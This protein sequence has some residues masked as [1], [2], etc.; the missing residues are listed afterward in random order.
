MRV[1]WFFA[2]LLGLAAVLVYGNFGTIDPCGVLRAR[3]RAEAV[4]SGQ[5]AG[6]I[7]NAMPDNMLDAL[8]AAQY[9]ALSPAKCV[10]LLLEPGQKAT[11]QRA[12]APQAQ[13]SAHAQTRTAA[14]EGVVGL[15]IGFTAPGA[16]SPRRLMV[17]RVW[18]GSPAAAAGVQ[19]GDEIVAVNGQ[20]VSGRSLQDVINIGRGGPGTSVTITIN[21]GGAEREIILTR[22]APPAAEQRN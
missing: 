12:Q 16:D 8:V 18:P 21:R 22:V 14:A 1:I 17:V 13:V 3:V 6:F 20:S 2:F 9:G 15:D 11:A 19:R 7:A 4:R 5:F 10:A